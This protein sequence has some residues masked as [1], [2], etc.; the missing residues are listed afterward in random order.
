MPQV[1]ITADGD[2]EAFNTMG[3]IGRPSYNMDDIVF[4]GWFD[5]ET[6][7][8]NTAAGNVASTTNNVRATGITATN[9][10]YTLQNVFAIGAHAD[11]KPLEHTL[12]QPG[13]AWMKFAED[14]DS[15]GDGTLDDDSLGFS[16]YARLNQG[17]T[18]GLAL[19]GT[20]AYLVADDGYT[21]NTND[22]NAIKF[23]LGLFWSW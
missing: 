8:V 22:D 20:I 1:M 10:G 6:S 3:V 7:T 2:N 19:K 13:I 9:A 18:D 14:V 21:S 5:D 11:W 23:A 4:P 15:N 12:V 16:L 17:I